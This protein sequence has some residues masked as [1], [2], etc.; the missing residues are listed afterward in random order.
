VKKEKCQKIEL[1]PVNEGT[2]I[3]REFYIN[4]ISCIGAEKGVFIRGIPEMNISNIRLTNMVLQT[5]KGIELTEASNISFNNV[6]LVT[7]EPE[8]LVYIQN[9]KG[10]E[11]TNISYND[12]A[13]VLFSVN[14]D[15]SKNIRVN[16][17]DLSK[18]KNKTE[19]K[20]GANASSVE[21]K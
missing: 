6:K 10:I 20:F 1:L 3:F 17:T 18:A 4:N 11:F 15:R 21:F 9:S 7:A 12:K 16:K 14:G 2:P 19:F 5:K 8:P 13:P